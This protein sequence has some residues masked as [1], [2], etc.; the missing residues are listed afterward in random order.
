MKFIALLI[1][2]PLRI[3]WLLFLAALL[4]CLVGLLALVF[5]AAGV[6]CWEHTGENKREIA[7]MVSLVIGGGTIVASYE[8]A[9]RQLKK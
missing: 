1:Y 6:W 4:T 5:W 2:W 9:K 8:W 3:L 7:I